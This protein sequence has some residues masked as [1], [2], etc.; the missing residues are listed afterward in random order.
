MKGGTPLLGRE[1]SVTLRAVALI[2]NIQNHPQLFKGLGEMPTPYKIEL[3]QEAQPYAVQYPRR[4]AVP[5][6]PKVKKE[7]DRLEALGVIKRV[8]EPTE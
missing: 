4:V 8:T 2:D 1:S 5:L 6:M 7:L 3:R